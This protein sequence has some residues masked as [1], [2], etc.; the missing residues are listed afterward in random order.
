VV[1][2]CRT[3]QALQY[4]VQDLSQKYSRDWRAFASYTNRCLTWQA[5]QRHIVHHL[6]IP[7]LQEAGVADSIMLTS[8]KQRK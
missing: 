3:W 4:C 7:V 2:C 1:A 6:V 5:L 8:F